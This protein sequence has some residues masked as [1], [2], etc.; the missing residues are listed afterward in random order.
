MWSF[1]KLKRHDVENTYY[2]IWFNKDGQYKFGSTD[3]ELTDEEI[4][5]II[6]KLNR[7]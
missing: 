4:K 1:K 7:I 5:E 3:H 2:E 6:D